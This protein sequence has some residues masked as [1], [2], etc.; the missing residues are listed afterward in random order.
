MP[1]FIPII[2]G[3]AAAAAASTGVVTGVIDS[4]DAKDKV[5]LAKSKHR[6]AIADLE[7]E[8]EK[9]RSIVISYST[10]Q[11]ETI[12]TTSREF[13]SILNKLSPKVRAE[14][15]SKPNIEEE[16]F[17]ISE[18]DIETIT[19]QITQFDQLLDAASGVGVA[20]AAASTASTGTSAIGIVGLLGAKASTGAA[21]AGL[22]GAAQTSAALPF[23]GVALGTAVLGGIV[24][25]PALL[26]AGFSIAKAGEE[27]FSE[28]LRYSAEVDK[29][30]AELNRAKKLF[31]EIAK[32]VQQHREVFEQIKARSDEIIHYYRGIKELELNLLGLRILGIFCKALS[33]LIKNPPIDSEMNIV[34]DNIDL[35]QYSKLFALEI[36]E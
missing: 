14:I 33:E 4:K 28:A 27:K 1:F 29:K 12:D 10:L 25:A 36:K 8:G 17:T 16:V 34:K 5:E 32:H 20:V 35:E 7:K 15:F 21:I 13:I 31:F 24:A 18:D 23:L 6:K 30:I 19:I 22:T 9:T 3:A 11:Q 26:I 2:L